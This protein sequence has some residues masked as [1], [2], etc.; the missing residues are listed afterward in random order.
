MRATSG[1]TLRPL[2]LDLAP[3]EVAA[4]CR[5]LPVSF[6][7]HGTAT[8][9]GAE[10][11]IVA[12]FTTTCEVEGRDWQHC[13][14]SIAAEQRNNGCHDVDDGLPHGFA[15]VTSATTARFC[16]GIYDRATDFSARRSKLARTG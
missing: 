5:H 10:H 4:R 6:F 2:R 14:K 13:S 1:R 15:A 11:F 12:A 3:V 8:G 7:R 16:F 9:N